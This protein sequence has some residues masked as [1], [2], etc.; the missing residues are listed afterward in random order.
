MKLAIHHNP[1]YI[2]LYTETID[3]LTQVFSD[4]AFLRK[5]FP[6]INRILVCTNEL[7]SER[8]L[9][10]VSIDGFLIPES[11]GPELISCVNNVS[12]GLRY[13]HPRIRRTYVETPHLPAS[14][15]DHERKIL[16][17]IS[18]GMQNKEIAE[19]LFISP[20]TVK[21][22]KSKL[23]TKLELARTIDLYKFA[24]RYATQP[25]VEAVTT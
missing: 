21:N 16:N 19:E 18:R 7:Y 15:T 2:F 10:E 5:H 8:M 11:K 1:A 6:H 25:T 3:H 24:M 14:I 22:H 9:E 12:K 20:H 23:M 17:Y 13:V 4:I